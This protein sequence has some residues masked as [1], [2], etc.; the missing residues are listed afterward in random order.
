MGRQYDMLTTEDIEFIKEQRIFYIASASGKE[1][2]LSPKGYDSIRVIDAATALYLDYPGS[3]NRTARDIRSGGEVTL[4][5]TAFTG[6]PSILRLFCKG[7]M[8]EKADDKFAELMGH[9][10]GH[11]TQLIR[12]L[13][14]FDIYTVE[15][16]CGKSVPLMEF[17]GERRDLIDA[18]AR[19]RD[20]GTLNKF[21]EDH[22]TPPVLK[23]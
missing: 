13:I 8:V 6:K 1:V 17:K 10:A 20:A 3:G 19:L 12:R 16:S 22:K 14:L 2:N 9:F 7:R 11:D 15:R 5:F 21:I 23:S 18:T 4:M